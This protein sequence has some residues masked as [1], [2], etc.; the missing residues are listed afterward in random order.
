[1]NEL[2]EQYELVKEIHYKFDNINPKIIGR[3]YK[4]IEGPNPNYMW[5]ISHNCRLENEADYYSP[6]APFGT[7]LEDIEYK[8]FK[9][10]KRFEKAV[11]W[12]GNDFF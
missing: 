7:T 11:D 2:V 6:S 4:I 12:Q 3:I 9:Y 5:T 1:M 8:L 10:V